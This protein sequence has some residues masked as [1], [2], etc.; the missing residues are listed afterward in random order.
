MPLSFLFNPRA[1]GALLAPKKLGKISAMGQ[2][3]FVFAGGFF[4]CVVGVAR[5]RRISPRHSLFRLLPG[6]L[7]FIRTKS[8]YN[9]IQ[10]VEDKLLGITVEQETFLRW[11]KGLDR[12]GVGISPGGRRGGR[13]IS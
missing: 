4:V 11:R 1:R 8:F 5:G 7:V 12:A 13:C 2:A 6:V 3:I 10:R 9:H